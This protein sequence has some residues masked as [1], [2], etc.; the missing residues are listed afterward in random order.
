MAG[1]GQVGG[2]WHSTGGRNR[3]VHYAVR[4]A[5]DYSRPAGRWRT[6]DLWR[7]PARMKPFITACLGGAAGGLFID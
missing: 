3:T 5:G 6:V 2:R 1:A 4:Y 7:H